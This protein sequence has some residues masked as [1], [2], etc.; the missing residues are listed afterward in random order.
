MLANMFK[1]APGLR[2]LTTRRKQEAL[3]EFWRERGIA[4]KVIVALTPVSAAPG[5][6]SLEFNVYK[7]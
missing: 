7:Q 4:V 5:Y 1:T 2:L 6:V 3:E